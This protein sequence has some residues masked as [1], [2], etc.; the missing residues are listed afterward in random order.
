MI[1]V[2]FQLQKTHSY[3]A[4][5]TMIHCQDLMAYSLPIIKIQ[6]RRVYFA[7]TLR[8]RILFHS[9]LPIPSRTTNIFDLIIPFYNLNHDIQF[10]QK[11][12]YLITE[13]SK[14]VLP[15]LAKFQKRALP[16][17]NYKNIHING[18]SHF[19]LPFRSEKI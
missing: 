1:S 19:I 18:R 17:R 5:I 8:R 7:D 10:H 11:T 16:N 3:P 13:L 9:A 15:F 12:T 4:R 2:I 14:T 6:Y